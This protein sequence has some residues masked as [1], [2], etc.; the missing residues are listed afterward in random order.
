MSTAKYLKRFD[1]LYIRV[2]NGQRISPNSYN[3]Y[4]LGYSFIFKVIVIVMV[5]R[6]YKWQKKRV[7]AVYVE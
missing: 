1:E 3:F 7:N 4:Q 6:T 5:L 2:I